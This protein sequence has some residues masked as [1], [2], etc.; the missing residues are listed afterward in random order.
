VIRLPKS[1]LEQ[2]LIAAVLTLVLMGTATL[3]PAVGAKLLAP[4]TPTP[5]STPSPT[6]P[7]ASVL[8]PD[9]LDRDLEGVMTLVNTHGFGGAFLL[10]ARGNFLTAA[11]LV[12]EG[13]SLRL[14]DNSGGMHSVSLVGVDA[15][16]G[17]AQIRVNA[18]GRPMSLGNPAALRRDDPVVVLANPRIANLPAST[19]AFVTEISELQL[20][21]R[22]NDLPGN[23]GGPVVGPGGKVVGILTGSGTALPIDVAAADISRWRSQAAT[24]V[25][26]APYPAY[27]LIR[28]NEP[29]PSASAG[30]AVQSASPV[31]ISTTQDAVITIQGAG[32]IAGPLLRVRFI[33]LASP[34]GGFTGLGTTLVNGSTLTVKVPAGQVVQDYVIQLTNGDGSVS[35]SRVG[36]TVTP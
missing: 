13:E 23:L 26:L 25:D 19:P 16:L 18:D 32:F 3:V 2:V 28:S 31:R 7:P 24:P 34:S 14:V 35:N 33:P 15:A 17:I 30:L 27:L 21:L 12:T 8:L 1:R 5:A 10:D 36:V 9:E 11:S 6:V 22:A 4:P 20:K 29:A